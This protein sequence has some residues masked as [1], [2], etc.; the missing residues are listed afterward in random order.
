MKKYCFLVALILCYCLSSNAQVSLSYSGHFITHPGLEISYE[1]P[2]KVKTIIKRK[3]RGE[4]TKVKEKLFDFAIGRY[5][6][7]DNH[8][9]TYAESNIILR[10]IKQKGFKREY[11]WSMGYLLRTNVG[12]TYELGDNGAIIELPNASRFYLVPGF[13]LGFGK[14]LDR[15]KGVPLAWQIRPGFYL[16]LPNNALFTPL[17]KLDIGVTYYFN[18]KKQ[19]T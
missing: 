2:F 8:K 19:S 4:K 17:F 18:R 7:P 5:V 6:H 3:R 13:Q 11:I 14:D 15:A 16:E 12:T 10:K 9:G 1:L